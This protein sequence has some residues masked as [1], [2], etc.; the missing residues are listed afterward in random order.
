MPAKAEELVERLRQG[1]ISWVDESG[2]V[3][4]VDVSANQL[5]REAADLIQSLSTKAEELAACLE[6]IRSTLSADYL[7]RVFGPDMKQRIDRALAHHGE[8]S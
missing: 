1:I 4:I 6:E 3:P 8:Q 2:R 5:M 7:D